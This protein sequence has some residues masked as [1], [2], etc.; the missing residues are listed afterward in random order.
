MRNRAHTE[1]QKEIKMDTQAKK[2]A[3]TASAPQGRKTTRS[4]AT[5]APQGAECGKGRKA[6]P[7]RVLARAKQAAL[8]IEAAGTLLAQALDRMQAATKAWRK[9][10][11]A[12]AERD[13]RWQAEWHEVM[14]ILNEHA[15]AMII[16]LTTFCD[17]SCFRHL[18]KA[19][20]DME[21]KERR[22]EITA[23]LQDGGEQ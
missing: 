20:R 4:Q 23:R 19:E 2:R 15:E 18:A 8:A 9:R 22:A 10:V 1:K 12:K 6:T 14:M 16:F 5:D 3:S 7:E 21:R 17:A 11:I 13:A